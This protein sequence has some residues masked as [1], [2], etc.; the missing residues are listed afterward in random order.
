MTATIDPLLNFS[1]SRPRPAVQRTTATVRR[2]AGHR[3]QQ[4][5]PSQAVYRRRRRVVGAVLAFIAGTLAFVL[6]GAGAFA[7]ESTPAREGSV[8]TVVAQRGDTLWDI[9]RSM[10][11]TGSIGDLV[12]EL[13]RLNGARIEAGQ[14]IRIP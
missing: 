9:A 12:S 14:V 10:V 11:P 2:T 13:V 1:A 4:A 3:V 7:T 5:R 6:V 8:R